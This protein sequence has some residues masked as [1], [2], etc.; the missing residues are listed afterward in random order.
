[1]TPAVAVENLTVRYG[2]RRII[3]RLSFR[4]GAGEAVLI[5]GPSG[6]GKSTLLHAICG[7]IPKEIP[8]DMTGSIALFGA[9]GPLPQQARAG[10]IG[11]VFQNPETQL[12]CDTVADE[13]AF[14]LENIA[15]PTGEM[16]LRVDRYLAVVGL[17]DYKYASPKNLSGGQKQLVVLA[18][19]LALEPKIL[20]LDEALSQLDADGKAELIA[21]LAELKRT[22]ITLLMVD[23]DNELAPIADRIVALEGVWD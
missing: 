23:H 2:D 9:T 3:D 22:G 7:L 12:F 14:G 6:I 18:A 16:Q 4:V 13:I 15:V 8:A 1:M 11:I 5:Q 17:T 21:K 20:L 19:V 10:T